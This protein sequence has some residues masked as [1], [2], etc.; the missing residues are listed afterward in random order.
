MRMAT[1]RRTRWIATGGATAAVAIGIWA[2]VA[3]ATPTPTAPSPTNAAPVITWGDDAAAPSSYDVARGSGPCDSSPAFGTAQPATSPFTDSPRP[4]DGT[5]CYLVTGHGY[6]TG[7]V[8]SGAMTQV[9]VDATP[10]T[11]TI[12]SPTATVVGGVVSI[13]ASSSEPGA[14]NVSTSPA[15]T[16]SPTAWDTTAISDGTYTITASST[17]AAGNPGS[18]QRVVTVDNHPPGAFSASGPTT[19]AGG[20]QIFWTPAP[21]LTSVTYRIQRNGPGG[22]VQFDGVTSGW[23]DPSQPLA[24]GTYTYTVEAVDV[25][26]HVTQATGSPLTIVVTAPSATAPQSVS[27]VSPTNTTPHLVW[28]RPVTFAVT[29][30]QVF[31]D[32]AMVTTLDA[33][34]LSF[35]DVGV[36]GQG[37]HSYV[38]RAMS[39]A[40]LGDASAPVSVVYDTLPPALAA[41]SGTA[42]PDG[43]VSVSWLPATDPSPGAGLSGYV[44]RRGGQTSPPESTTAGTAVC[45]VTTTATGCVDRAVT[46]GSIYG[47]SVFAIDG[48]G[49]QTHQSVSVRA[50]DSIA[51][52]PVTGFKASVGPTNVHLVWDAPARQGNDADL[53]GYRL[54]KLGA[55]IKRPTNPRDGSEVCP[56]LGFRDTDCFIQNLTT[57]KPVTFAIYAEDAV[58]NLSAPT[59]LTVTPNATDHKKPGLPKKVRL[60]RVGAKITMTWVSPKDRDLSKFRVTLYNNGPASRPSKGK[61]IITGRVLRAT[62]ALKAGQIVYV[63]LFAIDL[64][65][66]WSRVTRLI[67]MPDRLGGATTHKHKKIAKKKTTGAKTPPKKPK[68]S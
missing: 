43:S 8:D 30:W 55:G 38:V 64:S 29:G 17:D 49:N 40:S 44:V 34:A 52:D 66:N 37:L 32:N 41:P 35:D 27:A 68:K 19:V 45:T 25:L 53:A 22:P 46:S 16:I 13:A 28:Q 24:L 48:A 47:Y 21:D 10:P 54:I 57:G 11:V 2:A 31:R 39:G 58:P 7:P 63:N 4:P 18:A 59:L 67:V 1:G 9:V 65:G 36:P 33:S 50:V 23:T 61:A 62:F 51:P 60:K 5:Y 42:N 14:V 26:G 6:A 3:W 20:P 56:G 15:T 12:S